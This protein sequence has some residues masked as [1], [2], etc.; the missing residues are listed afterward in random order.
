MYQKNLVGDPVDVHISRIANKRPWKVRIKIGAGSNNV[1]LT[2]GWDK[3]VRKFNK[4]E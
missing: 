2:V 1:I 3:V 4:H